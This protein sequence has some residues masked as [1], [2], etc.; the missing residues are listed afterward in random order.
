M[1]ASVFFCCRF[2]Y[3]SLASPIASF[4]DAEFA[5]NALQ[6]I[7]A[8]CLAG[9]FAERIIGGVEV[10]RDKIERQPFSQCALG[11]FEMLGGCSQRRLVAHAGNQ[12]LFAKGGPSPQDEVRQGLFQFGQTL[13]GKHRGE[14]VINLW[15]EL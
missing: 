5:K 1:S 12:D 6:Q 11:G 15:P 10:D 13:A 8:G 4:A 7:C 14:G 9:D 2:S 3:S